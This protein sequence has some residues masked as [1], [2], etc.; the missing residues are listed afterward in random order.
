MKLEQFIVDRITE[1]GD[2]GWILSADGD[3]VDAYVNEQED[4]DQAAQHLKSKVE[5]LLTE[6]H[7]NSRPVKFLVW[8]KR[9]ER[10]GIVNRLHA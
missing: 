1:T 7:Q 8:N 4:L 10:S 6:A 5:V 2:L 9:E 3:T